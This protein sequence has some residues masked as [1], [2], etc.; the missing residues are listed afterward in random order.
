MTRERLA[1]A[2]GISHG[3]LV[4]IETKRVTEPRFSTIPK[5]AEAPGV[6]PSRLVD[7]E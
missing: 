5:L 6:G 2:A 3:T 1:K 7:Q 4:D